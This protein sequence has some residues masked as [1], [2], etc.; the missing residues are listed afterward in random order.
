MKKTLVVAVA[1]VFVLTGC[2]WLKEHGFTA[3]GTK[4]CDVGPV[5]VHVPNNQITPIPDIVV[6]GKVKQICW[7]LDSD[8]AK[9][10]QFFTDSIQIDDPGGSA[11]ANCKKGQKD[12][13]LDG[14][15]K[16]RCKDHNPHKDKYKYL[17][18]V[19][20]QNGNDGPQLDPWI[21]NN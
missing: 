9:T 3:Q 1:S 17:I 8:A 5:M 7:Q 18:K 20:L 21:V 2:H 12:G 19:Y 4:P 13:D 6:D 15:D 14:P 11:F 10:Y 16:I